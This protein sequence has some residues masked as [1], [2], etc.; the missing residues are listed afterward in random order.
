M[1]DQVFT[2]LISR[3]SGISSMAREYSYEEILNHA[4]KLFSIQAGELEQIP[5]P[6]CKKDGKAVSY[7]Y[8]LKDVLK[9]IGFYDWSFEQL[10]DEISKVIFGRRT[11]Y[12]VL[13]D[14]LFLEQI[15]VD[16]TPFRFD[17]MDEKGCSVPVLNLEDGIS[18]IIKAKSLIEKETPRL[19]IGAG[20]NF[21]DFWE[22]PRLLYGMNPNYQFYLRCHQNL[23]EQTFTYYGVPVK[24]TA[25]A[26]F[27]PGRRKRV[28]AM[29]P[30]ERGWS[31]V[32]LVKDCGLIPYLFYKNHGCEAVMVGANG[33]PYPYL[34]KYI[35][36]VKM[37][38]LPEGSEEEK[39]AYI[40]KNAMEIDCL[41]LR[42]C[43]PTNI[44]VAKYYKHYNP[45]GRIYIGLDA[46][47]GWMDRIP[48]YEE[49]FTIF[50]DCCD[51]IATSCKVMQNH[52]NQ[53]W[54]WKIESIP[55]G[56]YDFSTDSREVPE[57]EKKEN[58]ILT[59]AR[60]GAPQKATQILLEAFAEIAKEVPEWKLCMV[61]ST[62]PNF[63]DYFRQYLER[64]PELKERVCLKGPIQDRDRLF[65]QYKKSKIFALPSIYE[66]GTPNV[67]AEALHAGCVLAVSRFDAY[68]EAIDNGR[69]GMAA[70]VGDVLG[71]SHI[72][73]SLCQSS[74]L[75][76]MSCHAFQYGRAHFDMEKIVARINE[77]IFEGN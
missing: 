49:W 9:N 60:I 69:C 28:V 10:A 58:Q 68:A 41:I 47:S 55:N 17:D 56:Y 25:T 57:F 59:V 74:R 31:N 27:K 16:E 32:E 52:L 44:D 65:S 29:A 12:Q 43:Y 36:G 18:A 62:E 38:F 51:V 4:A 3:Y 14:P 37:E 67:V 20:R 21:S 23:P 61:G 6:S 63:E 50:L 40:A 5:L 39:W 46:N 45:E 54:P 26:A 15:P 30:Y 2:D 64:F 73:L 34:E 76:E 42:G 66:G 13:P 77:M 19:V 70:D 71:F 7:Q 48:W 33:G 24:Q 35:K 8:V 72:L 11:Q 22:I 75:E 1:Q 53:K